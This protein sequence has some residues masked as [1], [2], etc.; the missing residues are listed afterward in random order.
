M[1]S[2]L[3]IG[4]GRFGSALAQELCA[5][6]NEVMALDLRADRVQ[7]AADLVTRAAAGDARDPEVL[8]TL[9]ARNFDCAVVAFSADV[10]DS[11]LITLNLKEIGVPKVV[12]KASSAV[13]RKVLE[14]IGADRVVFPEYEM[15]QKVAQGLSSSN[16][17]NFIEFSEDYGIMELSVPRSWQGKTLRE[18]DVRNAF[19][20]TII[21][22]RSGASGTLNVSPRADVPMEEGDNVVALGRSEDIN[23]LSEVQ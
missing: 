23:R 20:V 18:L 16:V 22:L 17:L 7:A 11:A 3:V 15:G 21:A 9:G 4:L 6:G 1:K 2:F 8:R 13:H 19:H 10:G 14:K 12:C 5:Q